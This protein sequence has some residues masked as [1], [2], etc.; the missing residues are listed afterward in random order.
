M[1]EPNPTTPITVLN[2]KDLNIPNKRITLSDSIKRKIKIRRQ[3]TMPIR[4]MP[5][6]KRWK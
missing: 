6:I 3:Y 5:Q 2:I 1:A 4:D